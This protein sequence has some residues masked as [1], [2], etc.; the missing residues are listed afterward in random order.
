MLDIFFDQSATG[1]NNGSSWTNAYTDS[2]SVLNDIYDTLETDINIYL[3]NTSEF[4]WARALSSTFEI[5]NKNITFNGGYNAGVKTNIKSLC[6]IPAPE[7]LLGDALL[8]ING[9]ISF[10]DMMIYRLFE[11]A[12]P[13][14][15][16]P[17]FIFKNNATAIFYDTDV[18][19]FA[20][21]SYHDDELATFNLSVVNSTFSGGCGQDNIP[22]MTNTLVAN[23]SPTINNN[24][25]IIDSSVFCN[26]NSN[27]AFY[28]YSNITINNSLFDN[29]STVNSGLT[30]NPDATINIYNSTFN[31][32][33]FASAN[34]FAPIAPATPIDNNCSLNLEN[35]SIFPNK[36]PGFP[37]QSNFKNITITNSILGSLNYNLVVPDLYQIIKITDSIIPTVARDSIIAENGVYDNISISNSIFRNDVLHVLDGKLYNDNP[38]LVNKNFT[39]ADNISLL[40]N[41]QSLM[42]AVNNYITNRFKYKQRE[43]ATLIK[44]APV[45][46]G[47]TVFDFKLRMQV[48]T[49]IYNI[50]TSSAFVT[51]NPWLYEWDY[52]TITTPKIDDT[53]YII[54]KSIIDVTSTIV[55]LQTT[56]NNISFDNVSFKAFKNIEFKGMSYDYDI[57][58]PG[59]LIVWAIDTDNN[60]IKRNI[61]TDEV[62][63][64]FPMFSEKRN[65]LLTIKDIIPLESNKYMK[66][67]TKEIVTLK[68]ERSR[69]DWLDLGINSDYD[70]RG[71][72]SHKGLT[73]IT[74]VHTT[75]G[76]RIPKVVMF[77]SNSNFLDFINNNFKEFELLDNHD[78]IKDLTVFEDGSL[79]IA[80]N[81]TIASNL[82]YTP[83]TVDYSEGTDLQINTELVW[84]G[85]VP[86]DIYSPQGGTLEIGPIIEIN[87]DEIQNDYGTY[88]TGNSVIYKIT[89]LNGTWSLGAENGPVDPNYQN[90]GPEGYGGIAGGAGWMYPQFPPGALIVNHP[91]SSVNCHGWTTYPVITDVSNPPNYN[92][93]NPSMLTSLNEIYIKYYGVTS[94]DKIRFGINAWNYTPDMLHYE[95]NTGYMEV[96]VEKI[97][98]IDG[99]T[100]DFNDTTYSYTR[101]QSVSTTNTSTGMF[102][103]ANSKYLITV[104][105]N[106]TIIVDSNE[107]NISG[108]VD[109]IS[110][111]ETELLLRADHDTTIT[112]TIE[113]LP[114]Y[115][116]PNTNEEVSNTATTLSIHKYQPRYDYAVIKTESDDESTLMLR[117][118]YSE[119]YI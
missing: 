36:Q 100:V 76:Q 68:D 14:S 31:N 62:V 89:F 78:G 85:Q 88:V 19:G 16:A 8:L 45:I 111:T 104:S 42:F 101:T 32:V 110:E 54:P 15:A 105:E 29:M 77:Q 96:K 30:S 58:T 57:S 116:D 37:I 87:P 84:T 106:V 97:S 38:I 72:L 24:I 75:P 74:C 46:D 41:G 50:V 33:A 25:F 44:G 56:T 47:V 107:T 40:V 51:E 114:L 20:Y 3:S 80:D 23:T 27:L 53:S 92:I 35:V 93:D 86:A 28:A 26:S 17:I 64:K 99:S 7:I 49:S 1:L 98:H 119:I 61:Y 63:A 55:S 69:T 90:M 9:S 118:N 13:S 10:Y 11:T 112:Y 82:E 39:G 73:Y 113:V 79:L 81:E 52:K 109:F 6:E 4:Y 48:K 18:F 22:T 95:D 67:S 71:L 12:Y 91:A 108:S 83:F 21:Y 60:I 102:L 34:I 70:L 5:H 59:S 115:V 43:L 2:L 103:N 65:T 117:E 94:L 66:E